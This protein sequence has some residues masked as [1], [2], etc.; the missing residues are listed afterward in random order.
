[1]NDLA[2][3]DHEVRGCEAAAG[4][5]NWFTTER[6]QC[7]HRAVTEIE[8]RPVPPTLSETSER[9]DRRPSLGCIKWNNFAAEFL[10]Q[11]VQRRHRL[12]AYSSSWHHTRTLEAKPKTTPE[13]WPLSWLVATQAVMVREAQSQPAR[14]CQLPRCAR[15]LSNWGGQIRRTRGFHQCCGCPVRAAPP[16]SG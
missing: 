10:N 2:W 8:P 4:R 16:T 14:M 12:W 6:R 11:V 1:M 15:H 13:H 5:E 3:H 9:G 7:V